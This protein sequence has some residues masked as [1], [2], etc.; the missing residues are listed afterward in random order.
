M[1]IFLVTL[2]LVNL[3]FYSIISLIYQKKE[4]I[5]NDIINRDKLFLDKFY[6][7]GFFLFNL[8]NLNYTS[9]YSKK[10]LNN[11]EAVYGEKNKNIYFRL[12]F[13]RKV[14]LI[15]IFINLYLLNIIFNT[16]NLKDILI[17]LILCI[18][19]YFVIDY[20]LFLKKEKLRREILMELPQFIN[21]IILLLSAGLIMRNVWEKI[22]VDSDKKNILYKNANIMINEIKSGISEIKAYE[23]FSRRCGVSQ[24]N[25]LI[26]IIIQNFKKGNS[27]IILSL[28]YQAEECWETRKNVAIKLG[29]EA[30]T[31]IVF[32]MILIFI[33]ILI[34]IL[35]PVIIMLNGI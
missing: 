22:V 20:D 10:I 34:L 7:F 31:K 5:D 15:Y 1:E 26:L 18:F 12:N 4:K 19:G 13:A 24:V 21:K 14:N 35:A 9:Y 32:P 6:P 23:N 8:F 33:A 3:I 27:D 17:L 29:E 30:S 16:L 2:I 11:I 25:K 28:K